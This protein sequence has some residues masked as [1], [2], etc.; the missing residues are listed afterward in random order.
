M[1]AATPSIRFSSLPTGPPNLGLFDKLPREVRD[2]IYGFWA[3]LQL[4]R[5]RDPQTKATGVSRA[6][7]QLQMYPTRLTNK[8]FFVELLAASIRT[9]SFWQSSGGVFVLGGFVKFVSTRLG[10]GFPIGDLGPPV[11]VL[12][13]CLNYGRPLPSYLKAPTRGLRDG[14]RNLWKL[15][16]DYKLQLLP[17]H[18]LRSGKRVHDL[19]YEFKTAAW[20]LDLRL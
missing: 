4:N 5:Y 17:R 1:P 15:H 2:M 16:D 14:L 20:G 10:V 18:R 6:V 12:P 13:F 7:Q 3:D 9:R 19:L 11:S 8:E